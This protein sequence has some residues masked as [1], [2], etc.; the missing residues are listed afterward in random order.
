MA[1]E[2]KEQAK[3][4]EKDMARRPTTPSAAPTP[5]WFTPKRYFG[6]FYFLFFILI[7]FL[8]FLIVR[9]VGTLCV[10]THLGPFGSVVLVFPEAN[11]NVQNLNFEY[12]VAGFL[13]IC[14]VGTGIY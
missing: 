1:L 14:I 13:Y 8:G 4:S 2:E 11:V 5:S 6:G 9:V 3:S 10:V 12:D 7:Y